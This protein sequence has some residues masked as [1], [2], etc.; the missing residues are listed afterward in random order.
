MTD[1][2]KTVIE[3]KDDE[4][5][6]VMDSRGDL[7]IYLPEGKDDDDMPEHAQFMSA[8]AVVCTTDAEVIEMIWNK[9]HEL[10][11]KVN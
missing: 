1:K 5:A 7:K 2:E 3:L 8:L 4:A 9:F 11:E 6:L 10:M